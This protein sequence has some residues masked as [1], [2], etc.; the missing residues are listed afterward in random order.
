[1][2]WTALVLSAAEGH[3]A[4]VV[5]LARHGANIEMPDQD[6]NA[7]IDHARERKQTKIVT[8]LQEL[9]GNN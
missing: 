6:G 5:A 1:M 7:A 8:L 9:K 3:Q 2:R 4:V